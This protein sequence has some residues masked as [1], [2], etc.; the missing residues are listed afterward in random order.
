MDFFQIFF[1]LGVLGFVGIDAIRFHL[2]QNQRKCLR[3]EIHKDVLVTG[4]YE[5][6]DNGQR[7]DLSVSSQIENAT[8]V[9]TRQII[10]LP[11]Q[12][13]L[14]IVDEKFMEANIFLHHSVK[15]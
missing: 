7:A 15:C 2:G 8:F 14:N 1:T 13:Y 10:S 12:F 5:V 9:M 4:E 3:E 11:G 6:Q